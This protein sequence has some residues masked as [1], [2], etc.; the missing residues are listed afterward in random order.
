M[1]GTNPVVGI[2]LQLDGD[3]AAKAGIDGVSQAFAVSATEALKLEKASAA[4]A[5]AQAKF[6]AATSKATTAQKAYN[7]AV[8]IGI[9]PQEKLA[10][11]SR[12][13][14]TAAAAQG[15]ALA[16]L[17][18]KA[19]GLKTL[20]AAHA[21]VT[22][23]TKLSGHQTAQ[24]SA[25]LQD[26]FVQVQA[27][28]SPMTALIQQ[29]SQLSAV[30]GGFRPALAAMGSLITPTTLAIGGLGGAVLGLAAAW[31]L[32]AAESSAF[33]KSLVLTNNAAGVTAGGV[34]AMAKSIADDTKAG[35]GTAKDVL[36]ALVSSGRVGSEALQ[37][38][39]L[40]ATAM[41]KAT[42]QS[43]ADVAQQFAAMAG[44]V[45]GSMRKLQDQYHF[46]TAAEFAHIKALDEQGQKQ[47]AMAQLFDKLGGQVKSAADQLGYLERG[48]AAVKKESSDA[49]NA[50]L[51][52]GRDQTLQ[53]KIAAKVKQI[54]LA[55]EGIGGL[56]FN[57][58]TAEAEL[59]VLQAQAK[60]EQDKAKAAG[61]AAKT[62]QA[63]VAWND[64]TEKSLAAQASWAKRKAEIEGQAKAA[65]MSA[66]DP[67]V[68]AQLNA[69][70]Q[71]SAAG[72]NAYALAEA[73]VGASTAVAT[74][75]IA[76]EIQALS[77]KFA[78]GGMSAI[79]YIEQ[80]GSAEVGLM[81]VEKA[82][83]QQSLTTAQGKIDN[84]AEVAKIRGDLAA[85]DI[86]ITT[87]A[88][89]IVQDV[90][91]KV[92]ETR[93]KASD[94]YRSQLAED[95][96]AIANWT[97]AQQTA[98]NA[99]LEGL[100]GNIQ[101]IDDG[102]AASELER[103][104]A[105]A[106]AE[107]RA[108]AIMQLRQQ[109]ELR[110]ALEAIDKAGLDP[111]ARQKAITDAE[112]AS[113]RQGAEATTRI[114]ADAWNKTFTDIR[115]G[116]YDAIFHGGS[117]GWKKLRTTIENQVLRPIIEA[118]LNGIA[119]SL[120]NMLT[121]SS[122]GSAA[123]SGSNALSSFLSTGS[124]A[125]SFNNFAMSGIGQSLGLSTA[126]SAGNNVSAFSQSLT[127]TGSAMQS[128][129]S[130][131][132][133]T[134]AYLDAFM[135]AKAGKWGT[136]IG[137]GVGTYIGGPV[138]A[139]IGKTIGAAAD[140]VFAGNAGTPH[141]GGYVSVSSTGALSDITKAQG[142][143]QQADTQAL[144]GKLASELNTAL[145]AGS[146]AFGVEASTSIRAVFEADGK[147]AAW[148]IFQVLNAAGQQQS[149]F[150]AK[151]TF[152]A[153][154]KTGFTEFS[155]EAALA[156]KDALLK[157]DL[158][159]WA[160]DALS[161]ITASSGADALISTVTEVVKTKGAI[162]DFRASVRPLGVSFASLVNLSDDAVLALS[163]A[164]GGLDALKSGIKDYYGA[165]Y[166]DSERATLQ[167]AAIGDE[168]ARFGV[169]EVPASI[170]A[171]RKLVEAQDT[172]TVAGAQT[173]AALMRVSGAFASVIDAGDAAA[174][175]V[176]GAAAAIE[177]LT[178]SWS[179]VSEK[180]L[181]GVQPAYAAVEQMVSGERTRIES[182][183]DAAVRAAQQQADATTSAL[184]KARSK[185]ESDAESQIRTLES[186]ADVIKRTFGSVLDAVGNAVDSLLG[187]LAGDGGRSQALDTLRAAAGGAA[188]DPDVL[189]AAASAAA[190][191]TTDTFATGID[192]RREMANT[193]ALLRS[194]GLATGGQM[195]GQLADVAA[196]QAAAE[197]DRDAQLHKIADQLVESD[198]TAAKTIASIN[199][200]SRVQ[201]KALDD[202][203][204]EAKSAASALVSIDDGVKTVGQAIAALHSAIA[205]VGLSNGK[206]TTP[207]TVGK[208]VQSG[209]A[210]A[211]GA[212][213]G[214]VAIRDIGASAANTTIKGKSG[215]LFS[216]EDARAFVN[217]RLAIGDIA[218]I[219]DRA[220]AEGIDSAALDALMG[221]AP[222]TS[223][224]T[225]LSNGLP[226]FAA[227]GT[228]QGG[229]R[230]VGEKGPEVEVT[231]P[232]RIYS[233]DQVMK[234]AGGGA[235]GR[236]AL[237]TEV[238][239]LREE[240]ARL[241]EDNNAQQRA[242]AT[243]TSKFSAI[244]ARWDID[245]L[246]PTRV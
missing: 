194:V 136:A 67:A 144:V 1:S 123:G 26:F 101:S 182:S 14:A 135:Q 44:D 15:A 24:L 68:I 185:V 191:V 222:G 28:G 118:Q 173:Y 171:F 210:E 6:D 242:I 186:Q 196:K 163:N 193:T 66:T 183:T 8:R 246:P 232:S 84:A 130:N 169:T 29:G 214:A 10:E 71:K 59:V 164:A 212:A 241:R 153:D 217:S 125:G 79:E 143:I 227:G 160:S 158:P 127:G 39:G 168:L 156:V 231:G 192:Y 154:S 116:L 218:G 161:K 113:A 111:V 65:G 209:G 63:N 72:A 187:Q 138:G 98:Q 104:M 148:G 16:A 46:L 190:K 82:A 55:K 13:A 197:A 226:A 76:G 223:L 238:R 31:T 74:A 30:F 61:D 80:S 97:A 19:T 243:H 73:N 22:S 236:D 206:P 2:K 5:V 151:G 56:R 103:Q 38:T 41:A 188:I 21:G 119:G 177:A 89:K 199:E 201:L 85:K 150:G 3:K 27:G 42:G 12:D 48:W 131:L 230:L 100:R 162:D 62:T 53:E 167:M 215:S 211:F 176:D 204:A 216:M 81:L 78:Q 152:S 90:E 228:F 219:R 213:G 207:T 149:G 107:D 17:K 115:S 155:A 87:R 159:T 50:M 94:T 35:I 83:L 60:A 137:E 52:I 34:A 189:K 175:V 108:V 166:S 45:T 235:D 244:T 105:F 57:A 69:E 221:Y 184:D 120:T 237:V 122:G 203:L 181:G 202:Q 64:L 86:E 110:K 92:A 112:A 239:A 147:D 170:V 157:V 4:L 23:A 77:A 140:K 11:L 91:T 109:I 174:T 205:A 54:E 43:G 165:F 9:A 117:D 172:S 114:Y 33:R 106:T 95:E 178:T 141:M 224:Q 240:V 102:I 40:A 142:G 133:S 124:L 225:A 20:E 18:D 32:G 37:A 234:M 70:W 233:F 229:A 180:L 88:G 146:K 36:Y 126:A 145:V 129:A 58:P 25:Q 134:V 47:Q 51:G 132:G 220:V 245:G 200:A 139:F 7:E 195:N 179:S 121:G 93:K 49:W 99:F 208:W 128:V 198:A 75:R 96:Q